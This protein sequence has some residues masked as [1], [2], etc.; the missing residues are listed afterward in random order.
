[1]LETAATILSKNVDGGVE[2]VVLDLLARIEAL[3]S[4]PSEAMVP[5][6]YTMHFPGGIVKTYVL[7]G[8]P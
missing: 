8:N 7:E 5:E 1:M 6:K 4:R 3:E 2:D